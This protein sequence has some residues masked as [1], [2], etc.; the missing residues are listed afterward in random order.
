MTR[1]VGKAGQA[2]PGAGGA[3]G[4]VGVLQADATVGPAVGVR[5]IVLVTVNRSVVLDLGILVSAGLGRSLRTSRLL[6]LETVTLR[7]C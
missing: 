1:S 6:S 4:D 3:A 2:V 5:R 7:F